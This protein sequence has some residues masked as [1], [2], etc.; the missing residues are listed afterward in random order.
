MM[1]SQEVEPSGAVSQVNDARLVRVQLQTQPLQH[2]RDPSLAL[3][4]VSFAS[5]HDDKVVGVPHQHTKV[6]TSVLPHAIEF[7]QDDVG[8]ERRDYNSG[9]R[10][11]TLPEA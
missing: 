5:A 8:Q 2:Q 11:A 6:A 10:F 7:V 4:R 1:E 9:S 3:Q